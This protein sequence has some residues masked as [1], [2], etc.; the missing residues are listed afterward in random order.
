MS[1][2]Y[3]KPPL[4]SWPFARGL[5]KCWATTWT[6]ARAKP[7]NIPK[8]NILLDHGYHPDKIVVALQQI[9]PQIMTKIRFEVTPKPTQ[10][11]KAAQGKVGFVPVATRVVDFK[12]TKNKQFYRDCWQPGT[13]HPYFNPTFFNVGNPTRSPLLPTPCEYLYS[14][15]LDISAK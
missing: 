13:R 3:F 5:L 15:K 6:N 11:E 8:I 2:T 4:S 14:N 1:Y 9:Y 12:P 7:V 10:A